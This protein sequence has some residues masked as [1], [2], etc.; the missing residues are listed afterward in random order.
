MTDF[1]PNHVLIPLDG[2]H[3]AEVVLGCCSTLARAGATA[4][5]LLAVVEPLDDEE[6]SDEGLRQAH[7]NGRMS[8]ESYLIEKAARLR[9]SLG[10]EVRPQLRT[11]VPP[12]EILNAAD[13]LAIDLVA[14]ATHGRTGLDRWR[15]GSVADRVLRS[16]TRPTLLIGPNVMLPGDNVGVQR[17]SVPLDGS[18][19]AEQ[20]VAPAASLARSLG[21]S[22]ELVTVPTY[23]VPFGSD[24]YLSLNF[25]SIIARLEGRARDYLENIQVGDLE[26]VTR[27][28]LTHAAS[29]DVGTL[30]NRHFSYLTEG[31]VVMTSHGRTGMTRWALGSVAEEV[32]R[33]PAP[34]LI[35]R[36]AMT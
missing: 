7:L 20:A 3:E 4:F 5:H 2:S 25:R 35:L 13:E 16:A 10:I 22:L 8:L 15:L 26:D 23:R 17:I 19:L 27:I 12:A 36:G 14:L 1:R 9:E 18:K 6:M 21:A 33:G 28:T 32:I 24:P 30:L 29:G 34:V 11:G 31:L